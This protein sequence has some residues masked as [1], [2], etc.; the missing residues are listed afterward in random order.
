[1]APLGFSGL[2]DGV[3]ALGRLRLAKLL[4]SACL[5]L[6]DALP[7]EAQGLADLLEGMLFL[8]SEAVSKSQDQLFSRCETTDEGSDAHAHAIVVDTSVRSIRGR[9][10]HEVFQA[11]LCT[12]DVRLKRDGLSREPIQS[13][14]RIRVRA[15]RGGELG[16]GGL[17]A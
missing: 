13:L 14:E 5:E 9:I 16:R 6:T 7:R 12:C 3:E 10:G 11:L 2:Q 4:E 17:A 8:S 1:M 15:E